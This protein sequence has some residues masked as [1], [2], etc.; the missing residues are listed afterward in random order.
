MEAS[1]G[2]AGAD[3]SVGEEEGLED[4]EERKQQSDD[5]LAYQ[6]ICALL[7]RNA[8]VSPGTGA[9]SNL[10]RVGQYYH[11]TVMAWVRFGLLIRGTTRF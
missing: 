1:L 7:R 3:E 2:R 9:C 5:S 4:A 11:G 6:Q 10:R 8:I